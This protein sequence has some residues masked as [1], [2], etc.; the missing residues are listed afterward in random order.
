MI[1]Q[2]IIL[3]L[4]FLQIAMMIRAIASWL[5][6]PKNETILKVCHVAYKTTEPILKSVRKKISHYP[7]KIGDTTINIDLAFMA[8]FFGIVVAQGLVRF[9]IP[10]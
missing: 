5:P 1:A 10:F 2:I 7:M 9:L 6:K 3:A 4:V 8:V